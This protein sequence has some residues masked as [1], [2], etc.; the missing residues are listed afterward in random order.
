[1]TVEGD[2][3]YFLKMIIVENFEIFT[4]FQNFLGLF[5]FSGTFDKKSDILVLLDSSWSIGRTNYNFE[6]E[7]L[8]HL[9]QRLE[10]DHVRLSAMSYSGFP[11]TEF[12]FKTQNPSKSKS[13][14]DIAFKSLKNV[15]RKTAFTSSSMLMIIIRYGHVGNNYRR[16]KTNLS[17]FQQR[18]KF[19]CFDFERRFYHQLKRNPPSQ[20][21]I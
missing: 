13:I 10:L 18:K 1:M 15:H 20:N 5:I 7:F 11:K 12:Y 19:F 14:V 9:I 2:L 17:R 21:F 6:K 16:L 4:F 8:L 3:R